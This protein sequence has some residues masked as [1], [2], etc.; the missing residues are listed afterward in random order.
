MG[1]S[2]N[3]NFKRC[4]SF[5]KAARRKVMGGGGA[6]YLNLYFSAISMNLSSHLCSN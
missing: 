4:I 5:V 1:D 6:K 3:F 2:E